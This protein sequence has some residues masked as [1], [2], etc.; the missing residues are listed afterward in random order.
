MIRFIG[1]VDT[2]DAPKHAAN[3]DR[4]AARRLE[5][6]AQ[7]WLWLP[8]ASAV[9]A[10]GSCL[11]LISEHRLAAAVHHKIHQLFQHVAFGRGRELQ[12][13]A[14]CARRILAG[15]LH[16]LFDSRA[17]RHPRHDIAH[18]VVWGLSEPSA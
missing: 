16:R 10:T 9:R 12:S 18:L 2:R 14:P 17:G 3:I 6:R 5:A 15:Q 4:F 1:V 13:K 7:L 11:L 8:P